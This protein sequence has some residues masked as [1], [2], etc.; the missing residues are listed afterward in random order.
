MASRSDIKAG[1][2]YVELYLKNSSLMKGLQATRAMMA[3]VGSQMQT[4]GASTMRVGAAI[5]TTFGAAAASFAM[6]IKLA[7]DLMETQSKFGAVFGEST[8]AMLQ[9][10]ETYANTVG[11]AKSDTMSSLATMQSFFLGMGLDAGKASEFAKQMAAASVDF[12]SFHNLTDAEA[13]QRFVSALSG[14]GEVLSMFGVNIMQAA[15]D[16]QLLSMGFKKST[17][18]ATEM[19]KVLARIAIIQR[20]MSK[21][22]ATK[23]AITTAGSFSNQLKK[24]AGE[25]KNAGEAIGT[26][27]LPL[28]TPL[29][30]KTAAAAKVVAE[31]VAKNQ[32]L[33]V[34][35]LKV[36]AGL[37][38][39]GAAIFAAG[40]L[41]YGFGV[42]AS[43]VASALGTIAF[44]ITALLS[45]VGMT[46]AAIVALQAGLVAGIAYWVRYTESGKAALEYLM[47]LAQPLV[48]TFTA[49][50][51][52]IRDALQAGDLAAAASIGMTAVQ[53]VFERVKLAILGTWLDMRDRLAGAWDTLVVETSAAMAF[54]G[55]LVNQ[56][57]SAIIG[58]DFFAVLNAGWAGFQAAAVAAFQYVLAY[59]NGLIAAMNSV[60]TMIGQTIK[61]VS[62]V[63]PAIA[64]AAKTDIKLGTGVDIGAIL[65]KA[66]QAA[67]DARQQ[68]GE[69]RNLMRDQREFGGDV[70]REDQQAKIAALEAD[71]QR[72]IDE[73]KAAL[74]NVQAGRKDLPDFGAGGGGGP[75]I[76][77]VKSKIF[78]TFSAAALGGQSFSAGPAKKMEQ[79]VEKQLELAKKQGV[80]FFAWAWQMMDT[81][82]DN[83]F[84]YGRR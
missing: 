29:V 61:Q 79:A 73:A 33:V 74:N 63:M 21:Q 77:E 17:Q 64:A 58:M 54:V 31:W 32:G 47:S 51:G 59:A 62:V 50:F 82:K 25:A 37:A 49:A 15:L 48:D 66:G 28:L 43:F 19:E 76:A 9:W 84:V 81:V 12:A 40:G 55:S 10:A 60:A 4:L 14:S 23:D 36:S 71:L 41:I 22:G 5:A 1:R 46:L 65:G 18:G 11:R 34:V 16:Q 24:L 83:N 39:A 67:Q 13:M 2:A 26:A 56:T 69:E 27:L 7:G 53:I 45:P 38:A 78:G 44:A 80:E 20:T 57:M 68:V 70:A 42:A 72:Q 75:A 3:Q 8:D 30:A 6:P 52:G 35:A